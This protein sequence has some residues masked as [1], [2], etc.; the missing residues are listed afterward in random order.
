MAAIT[1]I[2]LVWVFYLGGELKNRPSP[3]HFQVEV[4]SP[5]IFSPEDLV[6]I[7]KEARDSMHIVVGKA[8]Q[9][10]GDSL[11]ATIA[12]LTTKTEDMAKITLAQE[13]EKYQTTLGA[14]RD[15]TIKEFNE[16]QKQLDKRREELTEDMEANVQKDREARMDAFN[17]RLGDVVSSYLVET[18]DKGVDLGAQAGYVVRM[19]ETHKDE[20]KKDVLS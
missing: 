10:L 3:K 14:L 11:S 2:S 5:Q 20:I 16:L 17:T 13:F 6:T 12:S 8:A 18:L 9:E 15:E 1:V 7:N 4:E 19:L